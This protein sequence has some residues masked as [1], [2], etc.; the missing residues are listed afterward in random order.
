MSSFSFNVEAVLEADNTIAALMGSY[1]AG[2]NFSLSAEFEHLSW[3]GIGDIFN[4]LYGGRLNVADL[5]ITI[6]SASLTVASGAGISIIINDLEVDKY[7]AVNGAVQFSE[8]GATV[9]AGIA[10]NTIQFGDF[11][12]NKAY[13]QISFARSE[14]DDYTDVI[15]GG[16]IQWEN[17]V[18]DAG[19]HLYNTPGKEGVEYTIYAQFAAVA[20]G[21]GIPFSTLIPVLKGS[22]L[23]DITLEGAAL[24]VA[25][26]D[27]PEF[28][29][30]NTVGYPVHQGILLIALPC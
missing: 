26:Q 21:G 1:S 28:G 12:L 23:D 2:G 30:F 17:F 29:N 19:V 24:I 27:D 16:E 4:H 8:K 7:A 3:T 20:A 14:S 10:S 5:D 13:V 9:R 22:F 25:S 11:H 6:G 18:F 15:F